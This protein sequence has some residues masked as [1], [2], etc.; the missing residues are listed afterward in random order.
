MG[1]VS[2]EW[3]LHLPACAHLFGDEAY[4][5][6][7]NGF[8]WLEPLAQQE[9]EPLLR[10]LRHKQSRN[11]RCLCDGEISCVLFERV[12]ESQENLC[13][14]VPHS[15]L[16]RIVQSVARHGRDHG[17]HFGDTLFVSMTVFRRGPGRP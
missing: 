13:S 9:A 8:G 14:P 3:Y 1:R 2:I 4:S 16:S 6:Y 17:F 5:Q 7:A 10:Y 11:L 12:A 15:L